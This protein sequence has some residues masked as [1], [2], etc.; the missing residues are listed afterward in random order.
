MIFLRAEIQT[1]YHVISVTVVP[2][3]VDYLVPLSVF[4]FDFLS[5]YAIIPSFSAATMPHYYRSSPEENFMLLEDLKQQLAE[6]E[7]R[8]DLLRRHL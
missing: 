2:F 7:K 8:I 1:L 3:V 6:I 4:I 5:C